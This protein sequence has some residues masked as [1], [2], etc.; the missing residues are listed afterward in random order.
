MPRAGK[1]PSRTVLLRG[2]LALIVATCGTSCVESREPIVIRDGML[3]LENQTSREWRNVRVTVND[4]FTGGVRSLLPGG[5]MTAPLRDF[6]TG[7]G[8]RFD[9]GRMSVFKVTVTAVDVDG[10]PVALSWGDERGLAEALRR[11]RPD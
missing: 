4:H 5:L 8:Q 6:Q 9:R 3:V 1:R 7:F 10:H 11:A 2:A